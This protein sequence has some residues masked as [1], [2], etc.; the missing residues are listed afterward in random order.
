MLNHDDDPETG[1]LMTWD[2][3]RQLEKEGITIGGHSMTHPR[4]SRLT[5][6]GQCKE[7]GECKRRIQEE[8]G[9]AIDAFAYPYGSSMDY[10]SL[11]ESIV[12]ECGYAYAVS[13]RDGPVL[14]GA[15]PWALRRIWVD[16][17]D[18]LPSFCDKVDG[19]LDGLALLDSGPGIRAWRVMNR[20]LGT[21]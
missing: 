3:V 21:K 5:E 10:T 19:R 2:E 13:N 11:T 14:S 20:L 4:L 9:H 17:T 15:N 1:T 6:E 8:L 12:K 18:C 16:G 7:I